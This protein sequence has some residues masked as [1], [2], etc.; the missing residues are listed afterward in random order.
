MAVKKTITYPKYVEYVAEDRNGGGT[1]GIQPTN[2]NFIWMGLVTEF[3]SSSKELYDFSGYHGASDEDHTL[4]L[5][6]NTNVGTELTA[7]L[8]YKM[9]GWDF[10]EYIAGSTTGVSDVVDS[11]SVVTFIDGKYMVLTGGMLT[12]WSVN[13]PELGIATVDVDMIFGN[14][15]ALSTTDPK[16]TYGVHAS[17]TSKAPY[18]WKNITDLKMD[19]NDSPTTSLTDIVG[20]I[21]LTI[22]NDVVISKGVDSTY[23]TKGDGVTI[24]KRDIEVSLDLTYVNLATFQGLVANHTK[25]NLSFVLGNRKIIIHNLLFPEWV[26]E[27][28]PSELVGQT[29]TAI[30]DLA[31]LTMISLDYFL[32]LETGDS[33]L[34]ECGDIILL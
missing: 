3:V 8:K 27:L 17:E 29:V 25:Q 9:Q 10:I 5:Q 1:W 34:L 13:I 33:I 7:S 30:T 28:K 21:T 24:N 22:T 6:R 4:E 23:I 31:S 19:A 12:K 11:I 16:G 2:P 18:L 20:D 26:A 14:I 15:T 32:L